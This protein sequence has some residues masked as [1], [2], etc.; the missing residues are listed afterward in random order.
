[1]TNRE[2]KLSKHILLA[3]QENGYTLFRNQVGAGWAGDSVKNDSVVLIRNP[4][5]VKYGL[6]EGSGDFIGWKSVTITSDMVGE[7]VPVFASI[8]VKT[9]TGK[10]SKAQ[11]TWKN[12][13]DRAG[14]IAIIAR[15]PDD[16]V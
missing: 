1:M 7:T 2:T 5:F 13:L 6:L 14:A 10:A 8:E 9:K 3:A 16:L 15:E 12:N 4:R 11:L